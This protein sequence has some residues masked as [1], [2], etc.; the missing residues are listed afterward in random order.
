[1]TLIIS[2]ASPEPTGRPIGAVRP[3]TQPIPPVYYDGERAF[4]QSAEGRVADGADALSIVRGVI[5][6]TARAANVTT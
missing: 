3:E 4:Y 2:L 1:M 5:N 6:V